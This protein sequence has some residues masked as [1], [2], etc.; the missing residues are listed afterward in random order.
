MSLTLDQL[1]LV[2]IQVWQLPVFPAKLVGVRSIAS[3][4]ESFYP[5]SYME[6]LSK[7]E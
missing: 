2:R 3:R 6:G 1:V 5:S 7:D 4:L